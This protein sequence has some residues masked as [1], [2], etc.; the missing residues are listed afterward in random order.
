MQKL[1]FKPK[2]GPA[3]VPPNHPALPPGPPQM[4]K[5]VGPPPAPVEA[6]R[7]YEECFEMARRAATGQTE[8]AHLWAMLAQAQA[9]K[10]LADKLDALNEY[11]GVY[12]ETDPDD[13]DDGEDSPEPRLADAIAEGI[14]GAVSV[15]KD[16]LLANEIVQMALVAA[17]RGATEAAKAAAEGESPKEN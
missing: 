1:K 17:Q 2:T 9:T 11:I 12:D 5:P 7:T 16:D 4:N 13:K 6:P 8:K 14:L 3:L 15:V 10:Q